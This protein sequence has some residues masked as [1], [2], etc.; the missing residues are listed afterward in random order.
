MG[1]V[2]VIQCARWWKVRFQ[3]EEVIDEVK[4][5]VRRVATHNEASTSHFGKLSLF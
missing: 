4:S 1:G 2:S 3:D 5:Q